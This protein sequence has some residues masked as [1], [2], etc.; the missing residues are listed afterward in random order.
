MPPP[1]YNLQHPWVTHRRLSDP[2]F[3]LFEVASKSFLPKVRDVLHILRFGSAKTKTGMQHWPRKVS[4]PGPGYQR[5]IKMYDFRGFWSIHEGQKRGKQSRK[6]I[7]QSL[8]KLLRQEL[9]PV[10][11]WGKC[12][13]GILRYLMNETKPP[14]LN[15]QIPPLTG[16]K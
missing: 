1:G 8:N 12:L 10:S 3:L 2:S 4:G 13:Q 14:N 7:D 9:Q 11:L 5:S 6:T 15:D 16:A